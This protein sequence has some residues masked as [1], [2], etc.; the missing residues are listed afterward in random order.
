MLERSNTA[1]L[2][3]KQLHYTEDGVLTLDRS[4]WEVGWE[5]EAAVAHRD[6]ERRADRSRGD[7]SGVPHLPHVGGEAEVKEVGGRR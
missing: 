6:F 7:R 4:P 1:L 3:A 5:G 2:C